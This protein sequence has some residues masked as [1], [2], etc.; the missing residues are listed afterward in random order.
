[1]PRTVF[2]YKFVNLGNDETEISI[3]DNI[4]N[5]KSYD[6]W[7]DKEGSEV[8]PNDFKEQL[9]NCKT[10]NVTIRMNSSGGE[11]NAANVISVAIQEARQAGKHI[12]C[13]ID[14]MCASAAVQIAMA[15]DEVVIHKSALM[16]IHNPMVFLYGYYDVNEMDK[17]KNLLTATKDAIIS[18]YTEKTGMTKQKI[19]NMM[20]EETYMT[21]SEAVEKGFADSLM[22]DDEKTDDEVIKNIS[23]MY[24]VNQ[25]LNLPTHY[26]SAINNF[27]VQK[28]QKGANEE[29]EIKTVQDMQNA[30]PELCNQLVQDELQKQSATNS[31]DT[32]S[33]VNAERERIKSIDALAGKVDNTLLNR[34]KYETFDSAEKVA[35]EAITTGAFVQTGVLNAMQEEA[36]EANG[37]KGAVTPEVEPNAKNE[38]TTKASNAALAYLKKLGKV[39]E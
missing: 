28:V 17:P 7:E 29:M 39:G 24:A 18:Y 3:Y 31:A 35:M 13:K 36:K 8:T 15:C 23:Q 6:W 34:A 32:A 4:A 38:E 11:V 30:Y 20:D 9:N 1:M 37:V 25:A 27:S 33:A 2:A 26:M 22:F 12:V 10:K 14:G 5:K 19:S 16:M 21:G